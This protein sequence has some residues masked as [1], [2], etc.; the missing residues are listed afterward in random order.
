[1]EG[2]PSGHITLMCRRVA[3][4]PEPFACMPIS[5]FPA[6][7]TRQWCA[8][9]HSGTGFGF[10]M[11]RNLRKAGMRCGLIVLFLL[12]S[13]WSGGMSHD[14]ACDG[15]TEPVSHVFCLEDCEGVP[16]L[17]ETALLLEPAAKSVFFVEPGP[18]S[19][20]EQAREPEHAPP[21]KA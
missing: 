16:T 15:P 18:M 2:N 9:Q 8:I 1:M 7:S 21:R 17:P 20:R 4:Q 14:H 6:E 10:R 3:P 19:P 5:P 13:G 12:L 11:M